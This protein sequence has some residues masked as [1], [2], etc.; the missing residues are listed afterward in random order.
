M[1]RGPDGA[2]PRESG[3][4]AGLIRLRVDVDGPVGR[5]TR[6]QARVLKTRAG[7]VATYP[8]ER[9]RPLNPTPPVAAEPKLCSR[10]G[11]IAGST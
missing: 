9:G 2:A 1:I 5:V 6:D 10:P 4:K 7:L 3:S 11:A 8:T